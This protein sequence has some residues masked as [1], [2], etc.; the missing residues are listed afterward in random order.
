MELPVVREKTAE[1]EWVPPTGRR[2]SV[3]DGRAM[4]AALARSGLHVAKFAREHGLD[5]QRVRKWKA[6]VA[7]GPSVFAP[8]RLTA[9]AERAH[10]GGIELVLRGGHT[11]RVKRDFDTELLRDVVR[12]LEGVESC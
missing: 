4:A 12:T 5:E 7:Q 3:D 8:V 6:R 10:G 9:S 1:A 11:V 2:W